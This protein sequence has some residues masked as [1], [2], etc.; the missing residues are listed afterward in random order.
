MSSPFDALLDSCLSPLCDQHFGETV[1]LSR[2]AV[3]TTGITASWT[4]QDAET[5][6]DARVQTTVVDRVWMIRADGYMLS[7][8]QATPQAGDR[9]TDAD[10]SVWELMRDGL[11]PLGRLSCGYLW[12]LNTKQI[13]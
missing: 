13:V 12:M 11:K 9:I 6:A 8:V 5:I 2:A 7:G 3:T 1:S 10:G 4:T